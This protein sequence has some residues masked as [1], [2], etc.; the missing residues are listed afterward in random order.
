MTLFPPQQRWILLVGLFV[1]SFGYYRYNQHIVDVVRSFTPPD[2]RPCSSQGLVQQD[3]AE[4]DHFPLILSPPNPDAKVPINL[5]ES[6]G[7]FQPDACNTW[8]GGNRGTP[9][10]FSCRIEW[11]E[12][13]MVNALI[14]PADVILEFGARF[15]TTSCILARQTGSEGAVVAVEPDYRVHGHFLRNVFDHSCFV[16]TVVGTVSSHPMFMEDFGNQANGYGA[17]TSNNRDDPSKQALEEL[18]HVAWQTIEQVVGKKFNVALIDCEGCLPTV[19]E[20]GLLAQVDLIVMEEDGNID[21]YNEWHKILAETFD[22]IW[23]IKDTVAP[24]KRAWSQDLRHSSWRRKGSK[25]AYPSCE[26]YQKTM[27]FDPNTE[28]ICTLC[29]LSR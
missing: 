25:R 20:S 8:K 23:Y 22:C 19:Y 11:D 24:N 6:Q 15:G 27:G 3:S 16:H 12:W 29:P 28:L 4:G 18:P 21:Y 26:D 10:D 13:T 1:A 9:I 7:K 14:Q 2:A 5:P 17:Q